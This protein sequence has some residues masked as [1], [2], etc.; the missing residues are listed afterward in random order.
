MISYRAPWGSHSHLL[1]AI[2]KSGHVDD[3]T[4]RGHAIVNSKHRMRVS[5]TKGMIRPAKSAMLPQLETCWSLDS[6]PAH[7][8][9]MFRRFMSNFFLT[10]VWGSPSISHLN[11]HLHFALQKICILLFLI[12]SFERCVCVIFSPL[13]S[14]APLGTTCW[15]AVVSS[16]NTSSLR[17]LSPASS[18][19]AAS[20]TATIIPLLISPTY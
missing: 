13:P 17:N 4:N 12:L 1:S 11:F 19:T 8:S 10:L 16:S 18:A 6:L 15:S 7:Q 3:V 5:L 2:S 14:S 20:A 9:S